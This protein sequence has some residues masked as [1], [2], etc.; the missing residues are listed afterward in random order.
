MTRD[1]ER[2]REQLLRV[3]STTLPETVQNALT[4]SQQPRTESKVIVSTNKV[5]SEHADPR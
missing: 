2:E 4:A 1:L 5:G 3:I